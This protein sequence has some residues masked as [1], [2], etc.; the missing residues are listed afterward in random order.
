MSHC[1]VQYS[2]VLCIITAAGRAASHMNVTIWWAPHSGPRLVAFGTVV[3]EVHDA[4]AAL[5]AQSLAPV[6]SARGLERITGS[7]SYNTSVLYLTNSFLPGEMRNTHS[8]STP[9]RQTASPASPPSVPGYSYC[10]SED[11][12]ADA[13]LRSTLV[14]LPRTTLLVC[15]ANQVLACPSRGQ[16][17]MSLSLTAS[18]CTFS[19]SASVYRRVHGRHS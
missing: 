1:T 8:H 16:S 19:Q 9:K 4:I 6:F 7:T 12:L 11:V 2:T 13:L 10:T 14:W 3:K 5:W 17:S 15:E 18:R